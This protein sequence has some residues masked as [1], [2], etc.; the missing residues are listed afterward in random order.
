MSK[1]AHSVM[2][3]LSCKRTDPI[4][5]KAPLLAFVRATYSDAFADDTA[6]VLI[7]INQLRNEVTNSGVFGMTVVS[8]PALREC[9][10]YRGG[11]ISVL[12]S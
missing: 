5:L 7:A 4:D 12:N 2:M 8:T 3:S 1:S 6:D 9:A 10:V 11:E